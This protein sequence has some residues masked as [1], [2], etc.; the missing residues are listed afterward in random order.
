MKIL[1]IYP[2]FI[3]SRVLTIEDVRAVPLG[4]Y[5]VAAVLKAA[6]YDVE[7][8]N[9]HDI[10]AS[11]DNIQ[12]ILKEKK[13][14]V[15][16]FSIL[17]GNRWG[18]LEIAR[19]AKQID[20]RTTIVFGGVGATFLWEHFLIHFSQVDY[21]V[22]GEGEYTFLNLV[23]HLE[24]GHP[25]AT[26]SLKGLAFR[27]DGRPIRTADAAPITPLDDLPDPARYFT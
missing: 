24:S 2:Y 6:D 9:W 12:Q 8:L 25:G 18:G 14:D 7:I 23:R 21:V 15:I 3:E 16:G 1:L 5:F 22:I 27:D 13:P 26:T 10:D 17:H 19:I 4:V 20:P 11:P